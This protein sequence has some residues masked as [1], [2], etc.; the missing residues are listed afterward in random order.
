MPSTAP[1]PPGAGRPSSPGSSSSPTQRGAVG[2]ER[3]SDVERVDLAEGDDVAEVADEADGV[4]ALAA[5]EAAHPPDLSRRRSPSVASAVTKLWLWSCA[6]RRVRRLRRARDAQVSSC[7]DMRRLAEHVAAHPRRWRR[8]WS[9]RV[10]GVEAVDLGGHRAPAGPDRRSSAR[11]RR[12]GR[13]ATRRRSRPLAHHGVDVHRGSP[14]SRSI[15]S[16]VQHLHAGEARE[17]DRRRSRGRACRG[18][19]PSATRSRTVTCGSRARPVAMVGDHRRRVGGAHQ[20]H[21][22]AG[23]PGAHVR[24]VERHRPG[25]PEAPG[26]E[27]SISAR[28]VRGV[29][30]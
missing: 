28:T 29:P 25:H 1:C 10:G 18:G 19:T 14:R 8:R 6:D 16:T 11:W 12:R 13:S 24:A 4:D 5:A 20:A 21:G 2:S 15:V 7:S 3:S 9:V 26:V 27:M 23:Q 17:G 22:R 30:G